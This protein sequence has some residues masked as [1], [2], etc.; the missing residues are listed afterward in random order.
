[1][2]FAFD[3]SARFVYDAMLAQR[4]CPY[5][6]WPLSYGPGKTNQLA[7]IDRIDSAKGYTRDNVQI[8]SYLANLMKSSATPD[9]LKMFAQ[10]VLM[11]HGGGT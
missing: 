11:R 7:S 3:L 9:Q 8:V 4:T 6:H 10:G 5:F 2:G 1:M